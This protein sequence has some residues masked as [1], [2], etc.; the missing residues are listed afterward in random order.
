MKIRSQFFKSIFSAALLLGVV[1]NMNAATVTVN[2]GTLNNG[3]MNVFNLPPGATVLPTGAGGPNGPTNGAYQFGSGWGPADLVSSFAGNTLTL[4]PNQ[5]GDPNIY[6]YQGPNTSNG[7]P[8]A[9][10]NKIM[11]ASLYNET[12]G[13]YVNQTLTFSGNV[14]SNTLNGGLNPYNNTTYSSVAFIKDFVADFSSST[15]TTIPLAPGVFN[16]SLLT[17]ADPGHHIQYGFETIGSDVWAGD[18]LLGGGNLTAI[19]N[20]VPEPSTLALGGLAA[21]ALI[22][23]R[24]K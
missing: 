14:L 10:G 24:N 13:V 9:P 12:T 4:R 7:G 3:F 8:G 18:P 19:I 1:A 16:I 5:I 22:R 15:S 17:S 6:W 20:P 23:R 21:L 2:P 11:D